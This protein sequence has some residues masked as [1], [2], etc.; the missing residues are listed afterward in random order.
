MDKLQWK[1]FF[2][3]KTEH[4]R[5]LVIGD[6]MIDKYYHGDVSKFASDAPV[7]VAKIV[8]RR[9][10]L[11]AAA[12]VANNLALMG[13]KTYLAGF[14]GDDHNFET[15]SDLLTKSEINQDG[16]ITTKSPT[17]TKVR[18]I[19]GH[20]Q[21]FRM[22]FEES[23]PKEDRYF[24]QLENYVC[25][26]LNDAFDAVV[27]AD[28]EKG[29]CTEYFCAAVMK[30]AHSHG[31]PVV[32][33]PY[34]QR[35]IKYAQA[36]YLTPNI[37][38]IN[39]VM[40]SP[41]DGKDSDAV[42]RAGRYVMRKFKVKNVL[43]TRSAYGVTLVTENNAVHIPTRFQEVFDSAGA[44]DTVA[45]VF[46]MALAGGLKPADGAFITNIAASVVISKSGT[47][48]VTRNDIFKALALF[49]ENTPHAVGMAN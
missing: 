17:T 26:R 4:C 30:A 9:A 15:L 25:M 44:S 36:D 22:D 1:K 40:L 34:G 24:E 48:A 18:I 32:V 14:V 45:A 38:K 49:E 5:V 27:I 13:C 20:Q 33:L 2:E 31:V 3:N 16:L 28:Y 43:A 39:K 23:S 46:S 37:S 12:N 35:W 11:G 41:V 47:Y 8:K 29:V 7:P 6:V 42:E 21:M 19:S 10:A